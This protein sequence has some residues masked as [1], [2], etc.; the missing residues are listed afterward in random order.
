MSKKGS[1]FE[2]ETCVL[3]S[4]WWSYGER[5]DLFWRTGGSGGRAKVRGRKGERT[6]GQHGDICATD[7][8]GI[9]L[10]KLLTIELKRGYS[11]FT[12]ADMLDKPRGA[13][14]QQWESWLRQVLESYKQA[15]SFS[16]LLIHKRDR[17]STL[18]YFPDELC[19]QLLQAG[20]FDESPYYLPFATFYFR[21]NEIIHCMKLEHFLCQVEPADIKIVAKRV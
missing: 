20:C 4:K 10:I 3:L 18:V 8:L 19:Q 16:W 13:A 11:K 1:A 12:V 9:D 5:T 15:G 2:R 17:R 14:I 6:E 21:R 7:P